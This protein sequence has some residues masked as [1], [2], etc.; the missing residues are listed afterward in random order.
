MLEKLKILTN[1]SDETL[2]NILIDQCKEYA[3]DY[4]NLTEYDSCLD[5]V[6]C[7][8][9]V[10]RFNK[11]Y[12]E[13]VTTKSYSGIQESYTND[14]APSVYTQLKRHRKIRTVSNVQ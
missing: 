14:F 13:G 11:I 12:S 9:C 8:M 3:K 7:Q 6:V 10:E 1:S 2:L 4:C 5:N